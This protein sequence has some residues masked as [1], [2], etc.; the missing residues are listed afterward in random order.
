MKMINGTESNDLILWFGRIN[1]LGL[2]WDLCFSQFN[3]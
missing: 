3:L 1:I 2:F